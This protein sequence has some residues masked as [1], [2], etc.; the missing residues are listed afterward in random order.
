[1]TFHRMTQT[2]TDGDRDHRGRVDHRRAD[3]RAQLDDLL[4][5]RRARRCRIVSRMPP[6]SP[7]ATMLQN[8]SSKTFGCLRSAS[9]SVEP[10]ST[11]CR[12]WNR[13]FWNVLFSCCDAQDLEALHQR[14]AGVDHHR[15]LPR[16][17]RD[18]LAADA[19]AELGQGELLAL[20]GDRGDDDLLLAQRRRSRRPCSRRR[21]R[22]PGPSRRAC[23][24]SSCSLASTTSSVP[25]ASRRARRA[26]SAAPVRLQTARAAVDHL[27]QLVRVR[28]HRQRELQRDLLLEERAWPATG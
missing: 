9:A 20:L 10:D 4:D 21:A 1:M 5:V 11:S 25:S 18:L 26:A 19:A 27:L 13:I 28:G 2:T 17:D 15:E 6:A 7:A 23:A 22:L 16:E 14:Q 3:R 8:R 24:L 12:T